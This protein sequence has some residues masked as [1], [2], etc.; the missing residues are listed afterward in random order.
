MDAL[1]WE[2]ERAL[3]QVPHPLRV[4]LRDA[5]QAEA[6]EVRFYRPGATSMQGL[7]TYVRVAKDGGNFNWEA[8]VNAR[9]PGFEVKN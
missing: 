2:L 1:G 9:T 6:T 4:L 5:I 8:Q 7:A 3:E